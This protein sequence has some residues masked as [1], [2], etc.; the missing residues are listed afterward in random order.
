MDVSAAV[1]F[2]LVLM[3]QTQQ[4]FMQVETDIFFWGTSNL[5]LVPFSFSSVTFV[6][7][8]FLSCLECSLLDTFSLLCKLFSCVKHLHQEFFFSIYDTSCTCTQRTYLTETRVF[9]ME[10]TLRGCADKSL[11]RPTSWCRRTESIV[12]LEIGVCSCA[13][14]QVFSCY[15]GWKEAWQATCAIS[16][17]RRSE[18]S[19]NFFPRKNGA[20]GNS[21]YSDRNIRRI[22]TILCHRQKLGGPV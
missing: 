1:L 12:S 11:A 4:S 21:R 5:A 9:P 10:F 8:V 14:L 13:E 19:S 17:T 20:E 3:V 15:M 18:L 6:A 22:C 16:T 7:C 2:S